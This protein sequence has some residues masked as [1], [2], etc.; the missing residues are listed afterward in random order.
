M[1]RDFMPRCL[2]TLPT[3]LALL[4]FCSTLPGQPATPQS[5]PQTVH[6]QGTAMDFT[7]AVVPGT[8]LSFRDEQVTKTV[9]AN[10]AGFYEADLPA[11]VYTM[12]AQAGEPRYRGF[13]IYRR[14]LFRATSGTTLILNVVFTLRR[15]SCDITATNKSGG[16]ATA[17]DLKATE[18]NFCGGEDLIPIPSKDGIPFQLRVRY[19]R[20]TVGY[21]YKADKSISNVP[22]LVEYNL[23]SLQADHVAYDPEDKTIQADGNVQFVGESGATSRAESTTLKLEDGQVIRLR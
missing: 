22:V 21:V 11:G 4:L 17:D 3:P 13:E 7:G 14:P 19:G 6:I 12:T 10:S 18:K 1:T 20:G 16:L 5:G 9:T 23:F 15:I 8:E 2:M